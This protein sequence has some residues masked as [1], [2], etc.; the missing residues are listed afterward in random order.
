M[1]T[2]A[3]STVSNCAVTII[4]FTIGIK[5]I[6][7]KKKKQS[8]IDKLLDFCTTDSSVLA[9]KESLYDNL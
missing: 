8:T 7:L 6:V 4:N 1:K 2:K 5:C 9:W 3:L